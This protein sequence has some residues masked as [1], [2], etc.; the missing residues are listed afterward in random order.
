MFYNNTS[1][2]NNPDT[3]LYVFFNV[4]RTD[5]TA[6]YTRINVSK[7]NE[8]KDLVKLIFILGFMVHVKSMLN[9]IV[10]KL[11]NVVLRNQ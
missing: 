9:L 4:Y 2:C 7:L 10:V 5:T 8:A 11:M 6:L 1:V 3:V